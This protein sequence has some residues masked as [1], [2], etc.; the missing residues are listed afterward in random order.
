MAGLPPGDPQLVSMIVSHLKTRGLFDQFR[1]DCLADV[2][3]KPAYLNLKQRVDN[4]VS[5]HLSNHTWSPHLNKN[6]L[7]NNIRQLVLQSGMLEQGVDRIVAQVVDPKVNHIFRPHVER[8]VREFLSPG[9]VSEDEPLPPLPSTE[10]KADGS[11]SVPEPASSSAPTS[12]AP[13][14][15]LSILDTISSLNQEVKLPEGEGKGSDEPMELAEEDEKDMSLD[16][17][18]EEQPARKTLEEAEETKS[19]AVE[20]QSVEVK[21]DDTPEE[22]G[23]SKERHADHIKVEEE[24]QKEEEKDKPG[25]KS[26]ER[27]SEEKQ[28]EDLLKTESQA[29]QKARERM[30]EEYSLEDSDLDGLSDITVSSVHTSDLS[31]F[32]EQSEDEVQPSDSSEE[33]EITTDGEQSTNK[34]DSLSGEGDKTLKPRRKAYVHKPF[35]YSRYYSDSDDEV[36]V[37]ERRRSA[38]KDKEERLLKRQQNRERMEERRK[39]K[40]AQ[41][42]EQ[43]RRK[44][45]KKESDGQR[46]RAKEARKEQKVLEKKMALSR[47]RKLDSRKQVDPSIKK[48]GDA[49]DG[50]KKTEL[51]S[52]PRP[53]QQKPI[54]HLSEGSD[55]KHRK[56]S[57]EDSSDG[58]KLPDKNKTHSFILELEQGSQEALKQRSLGKFDRQPRKERKE[59]EQSLSEE[60]SKL[61]KKPEYPADDSS[62]SE[63]AKVT[64]DEKEKK[65]K[66]KSERKLSTSAKDLK[67]SGSDVAPEEGSRDKKMKALSVESTK[68]DKNRDKDKIKEKEKLK[69]K[70]LI[71]GEAKVLS[72]PD[73]AGSKERSDM[74]PGSEGGKKREKH[75]DL[76]KRSKSHSEDRQGDKSK[77]KADNREGEKPKS[78]S[79]ANKDPKR[80]K[81][82]KEKTLQR[83]KSRE[84]TKTPVLS[85]MEKKSVEG[86][87]MLKSESVK[88]KKQK[89]SDSPLPEKSEAKKK[90][91]DKKEKAEKKEES[92]KEKK[93][94]KVVSKSEEHLKKETLLPDTSTDSEPVANPAITSD[95]TCDA[96]SDITPEPSECE[97][98]PQPR[99]MMPIEADALLT[100]MDVCTSA[101]A[102][103]P[104]TRL[105]HVTLLDA[106]LKMKEAALALLSMDPDSAL[107][108]S[109][110]HTEPGQGPATAEVME[111][112]ADDSTNVP[113]TGELPPAEH[114]P[115]TSG[116]PKI[117]D[118]EMEVSVG[119]TAEILPPQEDLI[120]IAE[121][122]E[123]EPLEVTPETQP[124]IEPTAPPAG[125]DDEAS[126]KAEEVDRNNESLSE[127]SCAQ[128]Q[129][130][131]EDAH[132]KMDIMVEEVAHAEGQAEMDVDNSVQV[133]KQEAAAAD[134]VL[135]TKSEDHQSSDLNVPEEK[136]A[137]EHSEEKSGRGSPAATAQCEEARESIEV[138]VEN[139]VDQSDETS[140]SEPGQTSATEKDIGAS[141]HQKELDMAEEERME[142]RLSMQTV[143][144]ETDLSGDTSKPTE[145]PTAEVEPC[146]LKEKEEAHDSKP[147]VLPAVAE[148]SSNVSGSESQEDEKAS[149]PSLKE[150]KVVGRGRRKRKRKPFSPTV[151]EGR[152]SGEETGTKKT[153]EETS[154]VESDKQK[155]VEVKT[156]RRGRPPKNT[157]ESQKLKAEEPKRPEDPPVRRGRRSAAAVQ[158]TSNGTPKRKEEE[159]ETPTKSTDPENVEEAAAPQTS[160]AQAVPGGSDAAGGAVEDVTDNKDEENPANVLP[161]EPT[162]SR[163]MVEEESGSQAEA[164]AEDLSLERKTQEEQGETVEDKQAPKEQD[165]G[166]QEQCADKA[167]EDDVSQSNTDGGAAGVCTENKP[168]QEKHKEEQETI[169]KKPA[170]RGRP[171]KAAAAAVTTDNSDKTEEKEGEQ[172]E[173]EEDEDDTK[174]R[175]T[176]RSAS[177]LVAERNKPSK[178]STRASRQ[179]GK[180]ESAAG[181][182]GTR[183]QAAAAAATK[184]G[185]KREASPPAARTRGG[186]KP[187]EPPS[188]RAKR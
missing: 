150:E 31:S 26:A 24:D 132:S 81:P 58:K 116:E 161:E 80:V 85:K 110:I 33:G 143:P 115:G 99:R 156:P 12:A 59:K 93:A 65:L 91:M 42:E 14:S 41:A 83:S 170:R 71:K 76:L 96:L 25:T 107:P 70:S 18:D 54:R 66:M 160:Q 57:V 9:S 135:V 52:A 22:T 123:G 13:G 158:E 21:M 114:T 63:A 112:T 79:D 188:K 50:L 98:E 74:E 181:S 55:E 139:N 180:D 30:K 69:E 130:Q 137:D 62:L 101:E 48:K 64:S 51:M 125:D 67:S 7:R 87:Q 103:L 78:C 127:S 163:K 142:G 129:T 177:R 108:T 16:E 77:S 102:R 61:K 152:E 17:E 105:D 47:K 136:E 145:Q 154:V 118:I 46:P 15:A 34:D 4:F 27:P 88:E 141:A 68:V 124:D 35:L 178:P 89:V 5:N 164:P 84:E 148:S 174:T 184:G 182:R 37:E 175:A 82:E 179:S 119:E 159:T 32:E 6:Q 43:D 167:K 126:K 146:S 147:E 53:P 113:T 49:G 1:R 120:V 10:T 109:F 36:T 155:V 138:E 166:V 128:E 169:Q 44:Q 185:R 149:A 186:Q 60:R 56:K 134:G 73:S 122:E 187:E 23:E 168:D 140:N 157:E 75:K 94:S 165:D 176:T 39:Q 106:D 172:N 173:G 38:A 40:A 45:R 97:A 95:D 153:R 171:P 11:S 104:E 19:A 28:E 92:H 133:D 72:R 121:A 3:T 144:E 131:Q 86:K 100:L 29:K 20:V 117:Q 8:V 183:G 2:D 90:K 151:A 162:A 111:A